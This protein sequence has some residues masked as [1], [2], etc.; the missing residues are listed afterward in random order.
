[1]SDVLARGYANG[2]YRSAIR[3]WLAGMEKEIA[4]HQPLPSLW[5]AFLYSALNDRNNAFRWLEKAY[6]NHSWGMI[7]LKD[8]AIWDPIRSDPRF[9]DFVKR[10]G[11]P[12]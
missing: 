1:M 10:V 8:D 4:N 3:A 2:D 12:Q 6:E 9:A 7:Y 5:M 11:L